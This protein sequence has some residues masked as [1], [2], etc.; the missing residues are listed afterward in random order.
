MILRIFICWL[1]GHQDG[2]CRHY[3]SC[4]RCGRHRKLRENEYARLY[5]R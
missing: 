4:W 3:A 1:R 2:I 5:E